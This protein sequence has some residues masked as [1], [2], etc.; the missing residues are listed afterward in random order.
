MGNNSK[1]TVVSYENSTTGARGDSYIK[2]TGMLI[3]SLWGVNCRFWSH[4]ESL[5]L[6]IQVSL[7]TVHK[8]IYKKCLDTLGAV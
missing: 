5:Y 1:Y 7:R 3:V 4:L 8:E 6:P 2:V